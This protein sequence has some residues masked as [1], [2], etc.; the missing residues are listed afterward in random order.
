MFE[1]KV[2]A[3]FAPDGTEGGAVAEPVA[4]AADELVPE[5]PAAPEFDASKVDVGDSEA[6]AGL[7]DAQL[8]EV[9][10]LKPASPA[11]EPGKGTPAGDTDAGK[12]APAGKYAG[13]YATTDE[14]S[15][16][17]TE[18]AGKLGYQKEALQAVLDAA[19]EAGEFKS[20]ELL[21]KKLERQLSEKGA[22]PAATVA[23]PNA[24]PDKGTPAADTF[25]PTDPKVS[26]A[27]DQLTVSQLAN[28]PLAQ[29]MSKKG[30]SL[31]TNMEEFEALKEI[32]PYYAVE[33]KQAYRDLYANNLK[34]AEGYFEAAK[35]VT[36]SNASVADTDSQAIQKMATG[37]GFKVSD[38]ELEAVKT[39]AIANPFNYETRYG[40]K[41]LRA[42]AVRDQFLVSVL[43][44]KIAEI[45][46]SGEVNGREQALSDMDKAGHREVKSLG[47]SRLSTKTR[48]IQKMPDLNDP[49]VIASLPD[50]ALNDPDRYFQN[51]K[52]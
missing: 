45:K 18:I 19:K 42:N 30:I 5:E 46:L 37:Q 14:L 36:Q 40:H 3:L 1:R 21:Y 32:N 8:A 17:V 23:D 25:S 15:K 11:A 6:L 33:F 27:V 35:T 39:A 38:A 43:P 47:T 13:K 28:S 48:A 9:Q 41:F 10:N 44:Q 20:V 52:K 4:A 12:A 49:D 34:Q 29:E 2:T 50:A 31:P 24:G 51:F 22:A 26:Q 16:G 7:D